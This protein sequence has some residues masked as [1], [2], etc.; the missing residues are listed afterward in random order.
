VNVEV[1]P[2]LQL[3]TDMPEITKQ[4]KTDLKTLSCHVNLS[5]VLEHSFECCI[6]VIILKARFF[7]GTAKLG[8]MN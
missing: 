7:L 6:L 1:T 5:K 8:N 2:E 3:H 4:K